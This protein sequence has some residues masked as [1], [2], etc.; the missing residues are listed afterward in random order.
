MTGDGGA[1]PRPR[2]RLVLASASPRRAELLASTGVHPAV[3]PV[4]VDESRQPDEDPAAYVARVAGAKAQA[5]LDAA[6]GAVG[7][8]DDLVVLAADTTVALDGEPLGKPVD[9]ADA[10]RMLASLSGRTHEVLT[11]V[12]ATTRA[13]PPPTADPAATAGARTAVEVDRT[14]VT[15]V[16]LDDG[17]I[18]WYV[19]TGEPLDKAGAYG[20]QGAGGAVVARVEGN[21]QTVIGLSLVAVDRVLDDLGHDLRTWTT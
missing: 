2:P 10:R 19:A 11:A 20:I 9:E 8:T 6:L 13:S 1:R 7:G 18:D 5:G 3:V 4:D 14:A 17:W 16:D 21:V 15:F 12:V